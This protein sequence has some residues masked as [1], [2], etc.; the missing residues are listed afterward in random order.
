MQR[1]AGWLSQILRREFAHAQNFNSKFLPK[2]NACADFR[3]KFVTTN[4]QTSVV[5]II[6]MHQKFCILP[7]H[8]DKW[9]HMTAAFQLQKYTV[10]RTPPGH[11][12]GILLLV[13][14]G[15]GSSSQC[16]Q[17]WDPPPPPPPPPLPTPWRIL[18]GILLL[19]P[20]ALVS[21]GSVTQPY[22][23]P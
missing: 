6:Y 1:F 4:L 11:R 18:S 5:V 16:P 14:T 12:S 2:V 22:K 21:G 23:T 9:M 20:L 8:G 19:H 7:M 15:L 13:S 3:R 10:Y 17:V